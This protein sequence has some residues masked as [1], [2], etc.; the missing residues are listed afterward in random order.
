MWAHE[1]DQPAY[2]ELLDAIE[3]TLP[4]ETIVEDRRG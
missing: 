1:V 3:R 2:S 4:D